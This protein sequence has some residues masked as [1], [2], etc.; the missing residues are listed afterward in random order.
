MRQI[1]FRGMGIN[2]EWYYGLLSNPKVNMPGGAKKDHWYISNSAGCP[3]AYEVRPE[4]IG[5]FT[6]LKDCKGVDIYE[7]DIVDIEYRGKRFTGVVTWNQQSA[8]FIFKN[9]K[10]YCE[11]VSMAASGDGYNVKLDNVEVTG[12]IYQHPHLLTNSAN[13]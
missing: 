7:S 6:G 12:N 10:R 13:Q 5:E 8:S 1:K 2:G 3:F 11:I 4:T 9:E